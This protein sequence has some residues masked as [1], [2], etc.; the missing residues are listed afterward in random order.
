MAEEVILNKTTQ[1]NVRLGLI[2]VLM[3]IDAWAI[4]DTRRKLYTKLYHQ[5]VR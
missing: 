5:A 4:Y 1:K 2:G 3:I